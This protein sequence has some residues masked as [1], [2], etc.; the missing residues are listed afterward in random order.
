MKYKNK[1]TIAALGLVVCIMLVSILIV[2][3]TV[4]KQNLNVSEKSLKN[5]FTIIQYQITDLKKKVI[6]DA[7]QMAAGANFISELSLIESYQ[8]RAD[9]Y[10]MTKTSH[11]GLII[12]L[13]ATVSAGNMYQ[14]CVYNADG[15]LLAFVR[16][17]KNKAFGAFPYK[18]DDK[19]VFQLAEVEK[20]NEIVEQ[21]FKIVPNW[22]FDM[23]L[24]KIEVSEREESKFEPGNASI[25]LTATTA[26]IEEKF[27]FKTKT[28]KKRVIGMVRFTTKIGEA[29]SRQVSTFSGTEVMV[30]PSNGSGSGTLNTYKKFSFD[31]LKQ[32]DDRFTVARQE[33]LSDSVDLG[34]IGYARGVWPILEAQKNV[35]AIVVLYSDKI[36]K[37]NTK[38]ILIFLSVAA[39]ACIVLIL[40]LVLFFAASMTKPILKIVSGLEDIA[41]GEGDLTRKLDIKGK[42]EIGELAKWFNLFIG[43]LRAVIADVKESA[44]SLDSSSNGL[45]LLSNQMSEAADGMTEKF[46][47]VAGETTAMSDNLSTIAATMEETSTNVSF[48]VSAIEQM[49]ISVEEISVNSN[50]AR[51]I[52]IDA[53][54]KAD[55][56]SEGISDLGK[57]AKEIGSVI[58]TITDISEQTSLLALNATIEAARA[59]EA[60]KGFAV[61]AAEIKE[62]ARQTA[63]AAFEIKEKITSNQESTHRSVDQV[64]GITQIVNNINQITSTIAAAVGEQT[65]TTQKISDN[66]SQMSQG[67]QDVNE[68]VAQSSVSATQISEDINHVNQNAGDLSTT[69]SNVRNSAEKLSD[70]SAELQ[71]LVSVFKT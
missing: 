46:G 38:Q 13:Y 14:A 21:Q 47:G 22:P 52:T 34:G 37:A 71:K 69:S 50:K 15:N 12:N 32:I 70:L 23:S 39:L 64:K 65:T 25:Q 26:A 59:G 68:H 61:V 36:A 41:Q 6:S 42:N 4:K 29:F 19:P 9:G 3:F 53:V 66:V 44:T 35:G 17:D 48:V 63:E 57:T 33:V 27:H 2:S 62:L 18:K 49:K 16:I 56:T 58:E 40:P 20:G 8:Q 7:N 45:F 1:L 10:T 51:E 11:I 28:K 55:R 60:G 31:Q 67:I 24:L 5:A 30:F 54:E 43:K